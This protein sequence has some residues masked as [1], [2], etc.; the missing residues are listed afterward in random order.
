MLYR[1][2]FIIGAYL[3][4]GIPFGYL[5]GKI[6]KGI[7]IREHGS[8]NVGATN[9][10]RV[11]G[12]GP[13]IAVY[14]LDAIKGLLPVLLAKLLWPAELP[15][16]QWFHIAAAL[17]AILGHVFAPY[18]KFKGGKGVAPASGAMLGLAPLPLLVSLLVFVLVFGATR[19]VSLGSI[20]ASIVFPIAVAVQ[21]I[22]ENKN[23]LVPMLAV[24][25]IL[26]LL[27]LV[28]HKANIVR[29]LQG[30]ENRIS[31]KKKP[32]GNEN[33]KF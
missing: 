10:I 21:Q 27:I 3:A 15:Q 18:L 23:P 13:G 30:K 17:A 14:L 1:I 2:L 28:T 20:C 12:K 5:A 9:V 22:L 33:T 24:G 19:Y 26:V 7:D 11:I 4:G 32:T 25:W 6:L 31:F 16:Q 29:L 8:K